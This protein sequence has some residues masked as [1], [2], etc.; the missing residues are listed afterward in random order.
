MST[1]Q[2]CG[3][4]DMK[5]YYFMSAKQHCSAPA[6]EYCIISRKH[7]CGP[8]GRV[9]YLAGPNATIFKVVCVCISNNIIMINCSS[10]RANVHTR[11]QKPYLS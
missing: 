2:Y 6:K 1:E 11:V 4:T 8:N 5:E 9:F 3:I 7:L 10:H